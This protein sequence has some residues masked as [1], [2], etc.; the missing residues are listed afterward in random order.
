[1]TKYKVLLCKEYWGY[2]EVEA[3]NKEEAIEKVE[4][5]EFDRFE[6]IKQGNQSVYN[7]ELI[8]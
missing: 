6:V 1:M 4:N 5:N 7:A 2:V 3:E 8:E